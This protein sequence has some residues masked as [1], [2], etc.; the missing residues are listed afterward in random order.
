VENGSVSRKIVVPIQFTHDSTLAVDYARVL[1]RSG[2]E[3]ILVHVIQLLETSGMLLP[4]PISVDSMIREIRDDAMRRLEIAVEECAMPEGVRV[5]TACL[6]GNAGE[7]ISRYVAESGA[8][9]VV[10][11]TA[12]KGAAKR[13]MVGSVAD[14][15]ARS[16]DSPVL[17]VRDSEEFEKNAPDIRRIVVPVDPSN[18]GRTPL[19]FAGE[20]ATRLAVPIELV[21]VTPIEQS[22]YLY[23]TATS[24]LL[25]VEFEAS[26]REATELALRASAEELTTRGIAVT[27]SVLIGP[28]ALSIESTLQPGDLVVMSSHGRS[29]V[30]RWLLGSVA[31]HLVRRGSAPVVLVPA[32]ELVG[33]TS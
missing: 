32:S 29:G 12:G 25:P 27:T 10:M 5:S 18:R 16:A 13:M 3:V 1:A 17:L 26:L 31:E 23:G 15:V 21:S 4:K 9:L 24:L 22:A 20:L 11:E 19:A 2:D 7:A 33:T 14:H 28:I 6:D 8:W 30:R